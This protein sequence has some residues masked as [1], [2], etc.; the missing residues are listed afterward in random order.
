MIKYSIICAVEVDCLILISSVSCRKMHNKCTNFS[1]CERYWCA[2]TTAHWEPS[3]EIRLL[4]EC[5]S[6]LSES[7]RLLV[8]PNNYYNYK[9][10]LDAV[11]WADLGLCF[12]N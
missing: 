4:V 6:M 1:L 3:F 7:I 2:A 8:K 12:W 10:E 11:N 5:R 9:E